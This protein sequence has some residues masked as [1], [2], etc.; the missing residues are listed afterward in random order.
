MTKGDDADVHGAGRGGPFQRKL[1]W[2]TASL[3]SK[4]V[5]LSQSHMEQSGIMERHGIRVARR[6]G[7]VIA[8]SGE[9]GVT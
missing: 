2:P 5:I 6:I 3:G 1:G 8:S 7:A 9:V 4:S